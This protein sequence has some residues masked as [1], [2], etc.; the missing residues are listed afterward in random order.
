MRILVVGDGKVGH[1]LAENLAREGHDV[2][3][4]DKSSQVL[5]KSIDMLDVMCIKGNGANIHTLMEANPKN[6]D[7]VI[8]ATASDEINMLCSMLAKRLG[9]K[10]SIVRIR[11]PE[12]NDSLPLLQSELS[13]DMTINPERTTALE[14]SRLLRY[15]FASNIE[16]FAKGSVEMV[17]FRACKKDPILGIPLK[18][19]MNR[20]HR[21]MQVLY[22]AIERENEVIIPNGDTVIQEDDHVY[23]AADMVSITAF[24][25]YL[26]RNAFPV[27]SVMLL[28]GG[29]ISYYLSKMIIPLGIAVTIVEIKQDKAEALS[30]ALPDV[31]IICGDG[32]NRDLLE[33]EGLTKMDAFVAL[34]DRD[35]ENMIAGLYAA[36][37]G[38]GKVIVKNARSGYQEVADM[39]K[40]DSV[41]SPKNITCDTILRY[42]RARSNSR[43]SSVEKIYRLLSGK[44]EALEFI[45]RADAAYIGVPL[46]NLKMRKDTLIAVIVRNG[47]VIVPFGDDHIEAGDNVIAIAKGSMIVDL[48]EIVQA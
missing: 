12:Y 21:A 23:V 38:V 3:I 1:S 39:L 44:A 17:E 10:Y 29:R 37:L 24:F 14:I 34:S 6:V 13:I 20:K 36:K 32:T 30:E 9:A 2:V 40:L 11:D 8:A 19:L 7:V 47:R 5:Q 42:V 35:E 16:S 43:G 26:G 4:I 25:K 31:N 41:V 45:A 22:C 48:Q 27:R 33:Q 46:R 18:R 28:G 15:P